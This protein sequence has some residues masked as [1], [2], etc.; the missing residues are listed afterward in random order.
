MHLLC[1]ILGIVQQACAAI[2]DYINVCLY[3]IYAS[4]LYLIHTD[5]Y[6]ISGYIRVY[7]VG[8][9]SHFTDLKA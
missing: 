2:K 9:E 4:G 7:V 1:Q 3:E 6:Q 5:T 8:I